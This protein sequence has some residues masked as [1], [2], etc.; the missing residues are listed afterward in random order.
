MKKSYRGKW[1]QIAADITLI[2]IFTACGKA[3]REHLVVVQTIE[4]S[5][6]DE[7]E[8]VKAVEESTIEKAEIVQKEEETATESSEEGEKEVEWNVDFEMIRESYHYNEQ[9]NDINIY[10]P[11]LAGLEDGAKEERINDLIEEDVKKLIGEKNKEGDDTLYCLDLDYEVK[12]LNDRIIS[13]LYKGGHGYISAG[14]GYP[15][16]AVATTIDLEEEKV[17]SLKD[18]VTDFSEL[19]D[20]LIA[21]KF[22]NITMWEGSAEGCEVSAVARKIRWY[23]LDEDLQWYTDGDNFI[24][25]IAETLAGD[26]NEYSIDIESVR[27][28]L[29]E[30]F[31]QDVLRKIDG[32]E[33]LEEQEDHS[34]N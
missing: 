32:I 23:G 17:I 25:I 8:P 5:V 4:E 16:K 15:A 18:I 2:I 12:F 3:Q 1:K 11:Q 19:R 6:A 14:H 10:Y 21:D 34:A 28:I 26:Y 31:L 22:E 30:T 9:R 33:V 24:V 29:E 27:H 7:K 13:I 20:M